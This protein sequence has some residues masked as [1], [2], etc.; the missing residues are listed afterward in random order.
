MSAA[1]VHGERE[2]PDVD[3][4]RDERREHRPCRAERAAGVA[5]GDL[6]PREFEDELAVPQRDRA[7]D[8]DGW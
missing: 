4:H 3:R 1:P 6:A 8:R 7:E 2:E 5:L